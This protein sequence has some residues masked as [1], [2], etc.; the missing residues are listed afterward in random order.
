MCEPYGVLDAG[1]WSVWCRACS[2]RSQP[3]PLTDCSIFR[4]VR[5]EWAAHPCTQVDGAPG[6]QLK[7]A[8]PA[9][10]SILGVA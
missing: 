4:D 3:R 5:A 2:W 6:D 7:A 8:G 1:E 9:P 10:L